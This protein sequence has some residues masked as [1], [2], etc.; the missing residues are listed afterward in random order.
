VF[1]THLNVDGPC[2]LVV[3]DNAHLAIAASSSAAKAER[4]PPFA[5]SRCRETMRGGARLVTE[6]LLGA[7]GIVAALGLTLCTVVLWPL[8]SEAICLLGAGACYL[9]GCG[10]RVVSKQL[11]HSAE[12]LRV[13][14]CVLRSGAS[15]YT[16]LRR[17]RPSARSIRCAPYVVLPAKIEE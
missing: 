2:N 8:I 11:L 16:R 5:A 7:I 1:D 4:P 12:S 15:L 14:S 13:R 9:G 10:A 6:K 17:P 3:G